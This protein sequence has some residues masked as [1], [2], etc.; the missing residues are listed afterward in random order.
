MD[1]LSI[2]VMLEERKVM[3]LKF[4]AESS[5]E[6][7]RLCGL[8]MNNDVDVVDFFYKCAIRCNMPR[9][10]FDQTLGEVY[11]FYGLRAEGV[12]ETYFSYVVADKYI[13]YNHIF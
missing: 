12:I 6:I 3:V 10:S 11:V 7:V 4:C 1:S 9:P 2:G 8:I 5:C 13:S